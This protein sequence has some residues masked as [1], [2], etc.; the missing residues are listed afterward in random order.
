MRAGPLR[1]R[2]IIQV[3]TETS[4]GMGGMT[5]TWPEK[6]W[7][8]VWASVIPLRGTELVES[9]K[10]EGKVTHVITMRYR[11]QLYSLLAPSPVVKRIYWQKRD[12]YFNIRNVINVREANE[13][14]EVLAEEEV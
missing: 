14:L 1:E 11:R 12:R 2:V 13:K 10:L 3:K 8:E 4:D 5:I 9:M 6:D 7:T